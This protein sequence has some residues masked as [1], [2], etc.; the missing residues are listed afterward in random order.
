MKYFFCCP[1][2]MPHSRATLHFQLLGTASAFLL[3]TKMSGSKS[4]D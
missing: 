4:A 3:H 2:N 1:W